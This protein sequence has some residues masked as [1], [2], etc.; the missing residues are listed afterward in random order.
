MARPLKVANTSDLQEMTD[1]EI[2]RK[3]SP[4]ILQE[5]AT[6]GSSANYRHSL[7]FQTN[8]TGSGGTWVNRI[9]PGDVGDH[10]V[11][12]STITSTTSSL[13]VNTSSMSVSSVEPF[14]KFISTDNKIQAFSTA[15][16]TANILDKT[17]DRYKANNST[18]LNVASSS[19]FTVGEI[20]EGGTSGVTAEVVSTNTGTVNYIISSGSFVNGETITGDQSSTSTTVT[21]T[22]STSPY[23]PVGTY[24]IGTSAPDSETWSTRDSWDDTY[25]V[26]GSTTTVTYNLLQKTGP[27]PTTSSY[28]RPTKYANGEA[29]QQATDVEIK[30]IEPHF[31][32]LLISSDGTY[33]NVG[34]Y[35]VVSGT[36]APSPGTWTQVGTFYDSLS[37]TADLIYSQGYSGM[38]SKLYSNQYSGVYSLGYTGTYSIGYTGYFSNQFSGTRNQTFQ[39]LYSGNYNQGYSGSRAKTYSTGFT[40]YYAQGYTGYYNRSFG[41]AYA[42][43]FV[44]AYAGTYAFYY[45]GFVGIYGVVYYTGYY[46][47]S[48][49]GYYT[50]YF[51]RAYAG[52]Y[53]RNFA[54][55]YSQGYTGIYSR[56]YVRGYSGSRAKNYV[57]AYSGVFSQGYTGLYSGNFTGIYSLGYSAIYSLGFSGTYSGIYSNQYAG[58]TILNTQSS[59]QYT[60]WKRLQ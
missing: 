25:K 28:N 39:G 33:G 58:V 50:G 54:G 2:E 42:S 7:N 4:L 16:Y 32:N 51:V 3:L 59:Q 41:R 13:H 10:P 20:I 45:G 15:D 23:Y 5:F 29:I 31:T 24:Y 48:F 46:N 8:G 35:K 34:E 9:R 6:K 17:L 11:N 47:N 60:F 12:P 36:T 18:I 22:G 1:F 14:V 55:I 27:T 38:Y 37:D 43:Y 19:G 57:R 56:N 40:G 30:T 26:S 21:S 53:T 52:V 44:R 49:I